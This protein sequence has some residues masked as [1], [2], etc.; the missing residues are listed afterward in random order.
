MTRA[1][2]L[3]LPSAAKALA[4]LDKLEAEVA[5]A[6]TLKVLEKIANKVAGLQREYK[7]VKDVADRAGEVWIA[8]YNKLKEELAKQPKAVGTRGQFIGRAKTEPPISGPTLAEMG[9]APD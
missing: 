2:A 6:L 3:A 4:V 7:P 8:T 9:V 5:N 1:R